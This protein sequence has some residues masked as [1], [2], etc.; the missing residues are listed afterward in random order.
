MMIMAR[1]LFHYH[2]KPTMTYRAWVKSSIG[3]MHY[4]LKDNTKFTHAIECL[5]NAIFYETDLE[6]LQAHVQT[7]ISSPRGTNHLVLEYK[8]QLRMRIASNSLPELVMDLT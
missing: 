4:H 3:E 8:Q 1:Q 6:V 5:Q 2:P 7:A